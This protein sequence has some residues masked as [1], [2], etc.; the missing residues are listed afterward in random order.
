MTDHDDI[1]RM[2]MADAIREAYRLG[3]EDESL[4]PIVRVDAEGRPVGRPR[5]G[6]SLIFYDIR[7]EREVEITRSLI[8]DTFPHFPVKP[9]LGLK[10][11]TMIDYDPSLAVRVA[12][13]PEQRLKNTL[14]ET[15]SLA[16]QRVLKVAESEKHVHIGYFMNGK[17]DE[18]FPGE[19]RVIV[20]SP[21]CPSYTDKPEMSARRVGEVVREALRDATRDIII[22]NLANVDV[23]GHSESKAA[24]ISAV[25]TVDSVLGD[26]AAEAKASGVTLM[27]TADH[28]TVEEWLYPD[29]QVNTGHTQSQVPFILA[30]FADTSAVLPNLRSGGELSDVAPTILEWLGLSVPPEMTGR[31][32]LLAGPP[33]RSPKPRVLLLILDGWGMRD[34]PYGN[35]IVE[36]RTPNFDRLWDSRPRTL[37]KAAGEAVGMPAKTVGNSE[38]GHLHLGAGRRVWLDRVRID[39]SVEDGDFFRNEAFVWAMDQARKNDQALHLM[40]I[41]SFYSSHGTLKHLFALLDLAKRMGLPKVFI[42]SFIG[43]RGERAESGAAYIQKVEDKCFELS[44]G[45]VVTIMG[46]FWSLDREENWDRVAKAYR[47]IVFGEGTRVEPVSP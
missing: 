3:Q 45:R 44:L 10:F 47:A 7:G 41:V 37:L 32:L 26:I 28:G 18:V 43:R 46:R 19:E 40:G 5:P 1:R 38:A 31:S 16:G 21:D 17:R 2:S 36:A 29:G 15:L 9:G 27:V 20:P 42:H 33:A 23:V 6:D 13:P 4:E 30:D 34:D 39:R 25:E 22:A 24:V 35:L 12:F 8:E 14:A 11:V